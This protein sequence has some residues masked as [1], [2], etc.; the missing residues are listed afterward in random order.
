MVDD[1]YTKIDRSCSCCQEMGGVTRH[2]TV[3]CRQEGG[4]LGKVVIPIKLPAGCMCRPCSA[5][6]YVTPLELAQ[7]S[8]KRD[9]WGYGKTMT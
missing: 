4:A 8:D 5:G 7:I 3:L 9:L 1:A 2:V 6:V